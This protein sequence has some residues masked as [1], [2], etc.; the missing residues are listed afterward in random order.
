MHTGE[1][2][3]WWLRNTLLP[4]LWWLVGILGTCFHPLASAAFEPVTQ[5]EW[6]HAPATPGTLPRFVQQDSSGLM[7]VGWRITLPESVR[8]HTIPALL[9]PQPVQG[10]TVRLS[11]HVIYRVPA[12][13]TTTLHQWYRP[14]LVPLPRIL[15]MDK[16]PIQV[17][18]EQT[19]HLR[20][21]F[22]SQPLWGELNDLQPWH[23][24]FQFISSTLPTTVNTLSILIGLFVLAL[25][26]RTTSSIYTF[27]GLTTVIWGV[28]FSLALLSELPMHAWFVWRLALYACTGNLIYAVLHFLSGVF[29]QHVPRTAHLLVLISAQLG[30][31]VFALAGKAA[32][33]WLDI[34]WTGYIVGIYTLGS[35]LIALSGLRQGEWGKVLILGLHAVFTV[36]LAWHDYA[37]Q[38]GELPLATL[39]TL[40]QPWQALSLQPIYLTHLSLPVFVVISLWLLG[41]DH[42]RHR[43]ERAE[44][45]LALQRQRD[46][47]MQD[48]HDGVGARLN[49]MLWRT[50][51]AP[52]VASQMQDELERSI[53]EL[54]FAINPPRTAS[55]TLWQALQGLE[56][57]AARWGHALGIQVILTHA[58]DNVTDAQAL[59]SECALHLY[60]AANESISNALRHSGA[61]TIYIRLCNQGDVVLLSIEDNGHGIRGWDNAAQ[62]SPSVPTTAMGLRSIQQRLQGIGGQC[63]IVSSPMGTRVEMTV[64]AQEIEPNHPPT[65]SPPLAQLL[66]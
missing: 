18:V 7:Q 46:R 16:G 60:K 40:P 37:L 29:R 66:A 4:A 23:D 28:L 6:L 32:E 19:G 20:G 26:W 5:V 1:P 53:E 49:L 59:S 62:G 2:R 45:E 34:F 35:L 41:Q 42:L 33:P 15:L 10:L 39:H 27:G 36:A 22:V 58:A 11:G 25:G 63:R 12:S 50:R 61:S 31:L 38:S 14:V 57:R 56:Q 3:L 24:R 51:T 52:L 8:T 13:T 30:W 47:I 44:H 54:R 21:W 65:A 9:F 55:H 48:I 64:P 17:Q 43:Q